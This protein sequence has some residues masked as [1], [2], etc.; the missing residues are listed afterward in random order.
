MSKIEAI[1]ASATG[2]WAEI[3]MAVAPELAEAI[4]R[5]G[6]HVACPVHGGK[7][8]FRLYRDF[9]VTGGG[10]CN[11]C[12]AKVDGLN[13]LSWITG[14][15][16]KEVISLVADAMGGKIEK[17]YS[18]PKEYLPEPKQDGGKSTK[19]LK[20]VWVEAL[21]YQGNTA[22]LVVRSYLKS[23][24]LPKELADA[25]K[26]VV[27]VHLSLPCIQTGK[28][29]KYK[30]FG[31]HPALLSLVRD[32]NGDSLTIH[33]TYLKTSEQ[34]WEKATAMPKAKTIMPVK[35]GA[36]WSTCAIRI[37]AHDGETLNIAEGLETSLAVMALGESHCWAAISA[38]NIANFRPPAG[39]KRLVV[40]ADKDR[41]GAG[42]N[43]CAALREK[44]PKEVELV[45]RMPPIPIPPDKKGVDWLDY[46]NQ[47][48][49]V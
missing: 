8:G 5:P 42:S 48:P 17:S 14:K 28:D 39:V 1:K 16:I 4:A 15:G 29:G 37:G 45:V 10:I 23:R 34:G 2:K 33:R 44:L 7:D 49:R 30:D 35:S 27:E 12:G 13:L 41:N 40:W 25:L 21:A 24:G 20:A 46:Y 47:L 22:D 11:T 36:V 19:R 32:M 6:R 38:S 3:A 18:A 9:N 26:G 31:K 43:A